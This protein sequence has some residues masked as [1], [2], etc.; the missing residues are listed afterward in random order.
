MRRLASAA[1][2]TKS[3]FEEASRRLHQSRSWYQ[4]L[5]KTPLLLKPVSAQCFYTAL[6]D[7]CYSRG[8]DDPLPEWFD[9]EAELLT[10]DSL[11]ATLGT[12][13]IRCLYQP[14]FGRPK[15]DPKKRLDVFAALQHLSGIRDLSS[16][17]QTIICFSRA[18]SSDWMTKTKAQ[19]Q[20]AKQGKNANTKP[21]QAPPTQKAAGKK[22][23]RNRNG[24]GQN[25]GGSG[26]PRGSTDPQGDG[27]IIHRD[28]LVA[29]IPGSVAFA[30]TKFVINPGLPQTFPGLSADAKL[31][32]EWKMVKSRFYVKPLVSGFS[33]QGQTGE[34]ILSFDPNVQNPPPNS[35]QQA[36]FMS[37]EQKAP[38]I[39]FGLDL[40]PNQVNRSDAKYIRTA[41]VPAGGDPKTYDGGNL[42]IST[43]GQGGT[44]TCCE[45]RHRSWF[46]VFK[47]TLLNPPTTSGELEGAGGSL[48]AATPFGAA[49]AAA[50]AFQLAAAGTNVISLTGLVIGNE[51]TFSGAVTGTGLTAA[52]FST[53]VGLNINGAYLT[54]GINAAT[55]AGAIYTY[56][57]TANNA[58]LTF[59]VTGTT[60]SASQLIVTDLGPYQDSE[61]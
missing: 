44:G 36:E 18:F 38:Y 31:Y 49:P 46:K 1:G 21:A 17:K 58:K 8:F 2:L 28:E 52:N 53:P 10:V 3:E 60:V 51:Y 19:K 57:A 33:T 32:G 6:Q 47:P 26:F 37:H 59:N 54:N 4:R 55:N 15:V 56:V 22:K 41:G 61:L 13:A 5:K 25:N 40:D 29:V 27:R 9:L 23:R 42:Y 16:F 48:T 45:L 20:R 7:L 35:Q 39:E 24:R 50:G 14:R 30:T 43:Y 11:P 34:T 12:S